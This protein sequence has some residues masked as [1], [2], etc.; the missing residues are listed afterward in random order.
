MTSWVAARPP[1]AGSSY[2]ELETPAAMREDCAAVGRAL[3]LELTAEA[4]APS[5][6]YPAYQRDVPERDVE[7]GEAAARLANVLCL[8]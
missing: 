8:D 4:A 6:G 2:D 5:L 1:R 7:I 3:R